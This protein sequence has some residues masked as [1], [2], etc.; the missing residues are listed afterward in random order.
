MR[1]IWKGTLSFSLLSIRIKVFNA[2]ETADAISFNQLHAGD[3]LGPVGQRKYCKSCDATL[4][5]E[6]I[7]KGYKHDLDKYITV[8]PEEIASI[9]PASSEIIEIIGF[10]NPE[11][12]PTTYFDASY[13]AA[14]ES[15]ATQK[16]YELLRQAM[17]RAQKIAIAKVI[18]REREDLI[19][20]SATENGLM[21]Q[22]LHYRHEVRSF[23]QVP[24]MPKQTTL[25]DNEIELATTLVEQMATSFSDVDTTDH[26]HAALRAMLDSK[27]AG[28]AISTPAGSTT[29]APVIDIMTALQESLKT[30]TNQ[31]AP[32]KPSQP[33][34]TLVDA[35][36]GTKKTRKHSQAA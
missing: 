4:A 17:S 34:L 10:V 32:E 27:V 35:G 6:E 21:I 16:P 11:E 2:I 36:T 1:S 22:K 3:C 18:L 5:G 14:P 33:L 7:V 28:T 15:P 30:R 29:H 23:E 13:F 25:A 12:I 19:A 26:F 8:A 9:K 20:L 31:Q 24:G